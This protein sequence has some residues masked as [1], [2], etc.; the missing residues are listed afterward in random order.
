MTELGNYEYF[1]LV[2]TKNHA[3]AELLPEDLRTLLLPI[4]TDAE[5]A[6]TAEVAQKVYLHGQ[7]VG[8]RLLGLAP[9]TISE[10]AIVAVNSDK[11]VN[12]IRRPRYL[13][14]S[15]S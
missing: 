15:A 10:A 7:F 12:I 13:V 3:N 1:V 2:G 9:I 14:Q 6:Y 11:P 8:F 5:G 4:L